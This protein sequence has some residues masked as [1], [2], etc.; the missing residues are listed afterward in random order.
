MK[1]F[2]LTKLIAYFLV[3]C[4]AALCLY[5]DWRAL[6]SFWCWMG[7]SGFWYCLLA[8]LNTLPLILI[9]ALINIVVMCVFT[10]GLDRLIVEPVK[11]RFAKRKP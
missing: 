7:P 3:V 11:E 1:I 10:I 6:H 5:L 4:C 9:L 2:T 8:V